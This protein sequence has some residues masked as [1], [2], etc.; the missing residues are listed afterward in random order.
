M[1]LLGKFWKNV[2]ETAGKDWKMKAASAPQSRPSY[3]ASQRCQSRKYK[4]GSSL[5]GGP[6]GIR[7][8]DPR[9]RNPVL[10]PAELRDQPRIDV[11][12][13]GRSCKMAEVNASHGL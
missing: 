7:T 4:D 5:D 13:G 2:G 12:A 10:Y 11:P 3:P 8:H 9:I 6:G 1:K